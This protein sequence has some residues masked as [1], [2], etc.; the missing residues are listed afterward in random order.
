MI[1][2]SLKKRT[3]PCSEELKNVNVFQRDLCLIHKKFLFKEIYENEELLEMFSLR[4]QVYRYVNFIEPNRHQLDIDCY[5]LYSTFLGAFEISENSKRLIGTVRIISEDEESPSSAVVKSVFTAMSDKKFKDILQKPTPFPLMQTFAISHR[6]LFKIFDH[7]E[8]ILSKSEL[9]NNHKPYEI[10]RLAVL[11]EYWNSRAKVEES[12]HDLIILN[13]WKSKP[14]KNIFV[15]A[16]HP[17]TKRKYQSLAFKI[18]PGTNE[19][20]Y[21]GISQLAIAMIM[22]LEEF[23]SQP[24]P[25]VERCK[26]TFPFFLK[27]GYFVR[28]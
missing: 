22:N 21:K 9:K 12:L 10:S 13:S 14:Q 28:E 17:R 19:C 25:Y 16:T 4:Y 6:D 5:D 11:P 26:L 20:L 1:G 8:T 23:L 27:H 2:F 3:Q 7:S 15:I 18:I 24:N